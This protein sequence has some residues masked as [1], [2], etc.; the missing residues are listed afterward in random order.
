MASEDGSAGCNGDAG[1]TVGPGVPGALV[2]D[3]GAED[4]LGSSTG[5]PGGVS[6]G[7]ISEHLY[8]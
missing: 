4:A 5:G 6:P 8:V 7:A 2:V 1:V 3:A